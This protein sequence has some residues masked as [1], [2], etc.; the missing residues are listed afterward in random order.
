MELRS[1]LSLERDRAGIW[2]GGWRWWCFGR[3]SFLR[4]FRIWFD[5]IWFVRIWFDRIWFD[6]IWFDRIWFDRIWLVGNSSWRYFIQFKHCGVAGIKKIVI[7]KS[8]FKKSRL[9]KK[10][11]CLDR[12]ENLDT[13]KKLVLTLR[14]FSISISIGLDCRDPQA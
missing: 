3:K 6:Q 1:N 14:T 2:D 9:R 12:W 13:L 4:F 11:F 5:R 10:K 7:E 8:W